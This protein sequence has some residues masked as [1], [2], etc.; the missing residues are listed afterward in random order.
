MVSSEWY[1][2]LLA[3]TS[4]LSKFIVYVGEYRASFEKK[5]Y[6]PWKVDMTIQVAHLEDWL[7]E[8]EGG[9]VRS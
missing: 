5:V 8:G 6:K 4:I 1:E 3:R 7:C 2:E 9:I